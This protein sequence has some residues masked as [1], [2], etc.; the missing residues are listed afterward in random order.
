VSDYAEALALEVQRLR[1]ALEQIR[2]LPLRSNVTAT[3][4][5]IKRIAREAVEK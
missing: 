2:D 5:E 4:I 1:K 3:V